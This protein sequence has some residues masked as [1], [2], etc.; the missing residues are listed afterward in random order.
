MTDAG[1]IYL[2][3]I[4]P[5]SRKDTLTDAE[6]EELRGFVKEIRHGKATF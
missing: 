6:V 3:S 4:Y 5:K 1:Q 2:L